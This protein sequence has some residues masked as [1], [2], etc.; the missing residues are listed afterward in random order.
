MLRKDGFSN[1]FIASAVALDHWGTVW[2][3]AGESLDPGFF[4]IGVTVM[5]GILEFCW[6][7]SS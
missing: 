1:F 5:L 6:E 3:S 2:S 7:I 4:S